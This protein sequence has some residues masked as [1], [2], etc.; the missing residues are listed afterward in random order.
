MKRRSNNGGTTRIILYIFGVALILT[1][2]FILLKGSGLLSAIPNFVIWAFVLITIGAAILGG[3][4][5][6][7]GW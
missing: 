2:V 3:I 6:T 7:R 4:G 1:A 5:K